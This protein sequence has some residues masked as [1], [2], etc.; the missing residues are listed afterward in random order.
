MKVDEIEKARFTAYL[1]NLAGDPAMLA[2]F[3]IETGLSL[4]RDEFDVAAIE[5]A[6]VGD[7]LIDE[8]NRWA[9]AMWRAAGCT[10]DCVAAESP[11]ADYLRRTLH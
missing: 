3:E 9:W 2:A 1:A 8:F 5:A 7:D 4:P 10:G 11:C 6:E